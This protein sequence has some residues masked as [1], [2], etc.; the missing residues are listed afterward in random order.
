MPP[1]LLS[2]TLPLALSVQSA[3]D[4]SRLQPLGAVWVAAARADALTTMEITI[5]LELIPAWEASNRGNQFD[6]YVRKLGA[7]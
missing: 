4:Y 6:P 3:P 2:L 7:F 1:F 5:V